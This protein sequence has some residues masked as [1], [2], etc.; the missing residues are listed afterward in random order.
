VSRPPAQIE[1]YQRWLEATSGR[2][3]DCYED[4][5]RWS[6]TDLRG[7]WGSIWR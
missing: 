3:F 6:V 1:R 4:L 2:R 5:W 7:F